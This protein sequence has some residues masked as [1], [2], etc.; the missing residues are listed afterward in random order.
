M[1]FFFFFLLTR[2]FTFEMIMLV[3]FDFVLLL[4]F[5]LGMVDGNGVPFGTP[6]SSIKKQSNIERVGQ[7]MP[8]I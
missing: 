8:I 4:V 5:F 7:V 2:L 6:V 3:N 1:V